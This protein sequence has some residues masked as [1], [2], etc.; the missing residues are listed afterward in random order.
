MHAF[1][2]TIPRHTYGLDYLS[3][4]TEATAMRVGM[5]VKSSLLFH[6]NV[7]ATKT[8]VNVKDGIEYW[9]SDVK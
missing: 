1:L 2:L 5:K 8:D 3:S 4:E 7:R 9:V 6:R